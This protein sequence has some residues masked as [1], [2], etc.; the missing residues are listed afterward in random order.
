MDPQPKSFSRPKFSRQGSLLRFAAFSFVLLAWFAAASCIVAADD[1]RAQVSSKGR[2]STGPGTYDA[3]NQTYPASYGTFVP[4][5]PVSHPPYNEFHASW[6]QRIDEPYIYLE[7]YG[8]YTETGSIIPVVIRE[9]RIQG[10]E[11]SGAPF[12]LFYDDPA[13]KPA[14]QLLSRACV[15]IKGPRSP[16]TPLRY[17]VLPSR[18]VTYAFVSGP[19]PEVS[20]CYPYMLEYMRS[21]NFELAGPIREQYIVPPSAAK[22]DADFLC[23]VQVPVRGANW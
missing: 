23:K 5:L 3:R 15:P 12:C 18:A 8:P 10:L 19:Y 13:S 20:R 4:E 16:I 17:D 21:M 14:D 7:H 2:A 1:T 22:T 6:V 9:M 11:P